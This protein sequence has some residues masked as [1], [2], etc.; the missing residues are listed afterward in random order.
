MA[1]D[2]DGIGKSIAAGLCGSVAHSGLMAA[3]AWAGLLPTFQ[4][5][6]DLQNLLASLVGGTIHPSILWALSYFNGS[7]VLAFVFGR[8]YSILPGRSGALKGLTFGLLGWSAMGLVLFP[9]LGRG[10]FA[11]GTDLGLK[12]SLFSL[13]MV[14]TYSVKLGVAYSIFRPA[15]P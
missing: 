14:L 7:V 2:L 6:D 3:K 4:P 12:P 8:I 15:R 1:I 13:A 9:L 10:F 5:Y 11:A